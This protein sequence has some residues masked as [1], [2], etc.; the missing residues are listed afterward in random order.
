MSTITT[1]LEADA[2]GMLHVP[3][4]QELRHGK[5][6]VVATLEAEADTSRGTEASTPLEAL[7]ELRKLGGLQATI[8]DPMTW[9][10]QQRVDRA[11]SGR[12]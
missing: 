9:Q 5:V 2:E 10:Q 12:D 3:V 1:I 4:P 6:R 7:K 11:L 8:P